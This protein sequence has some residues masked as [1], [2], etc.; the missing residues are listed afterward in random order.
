MHASRLG[1]LFK[2]IN[3]SAEGRQRLFYHS[4]FFS[5]SHWYTNDVAL[6]ECDLTNEDRGAADQ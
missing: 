3:N 2:M 1:L 6:I 5:R 4:F